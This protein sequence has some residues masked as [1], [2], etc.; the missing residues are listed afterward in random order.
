AVNLADASALPDGFVDTITL[1]SGAGGGGDTI[2]LTLSGALLR[3]NDG[4]G[5]LPEVLI[6]GFDVFDIVDVRAGGGADVVDASALGTAGP[7]LILEGGF[8]VDQLVGSARADRFIG[9]DG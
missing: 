6:S 2:A 1:D 4:V 7:S 8:G 9:G 3:V 5:P